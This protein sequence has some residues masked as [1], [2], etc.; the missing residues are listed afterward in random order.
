MEH[1]VIEPA[2]GFR[3]EY[4]GRLVVLSGD[5]AYCD[6][7]I[8]NAQGV[9]LLIHEVMA[10]PSGTDIESPS[11]ARMMEAHTSPQQVG[12]ICSQVRP[13]MLVYSHIHK[14][15]G[16]IDDEIVR[17]TREAYDGEFLVGQDLDSFEI[18]N[19]VKKIN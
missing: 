11:V 14:A 4:D 9:D 6:N 19:T 2:F 12:D 17:G 7:L 5:T 13:K 18:G 8:R 3:V 15:M 16:A 10:I 1:N